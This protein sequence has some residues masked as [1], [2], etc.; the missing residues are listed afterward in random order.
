MGDSNVRERH[1]TSL[2]QLGILMSRFIVGLTGGIGSGKTAVSNAFAQLGIDII[3]A[4]VCARD[5]VV[6]GSDALQQ[7]AQH[8]GNGI[9]TEN[10]ELDRAALRQ[11]VFSNEAEKTWLNQLLH[12]LIRQ[13]MLDQ[14]SASQS[15]YCILAVPLLLENQMQSMV[16]RVLVV[17]VS[18]ELQIKRVI[19]RDQSEEKLI[20]SI[21]KSQLDRDSRLAFA[22]DVIDNQ[23]DL[24]ALQQQVDILHQN[25]LAMATQ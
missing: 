23:T 25:Y 1:S 13:R 5:V 22:D 7:I 12:P 19:D 18:P 6:K 9:L 4:D 21:M 17:D 8:F 15:T 2:Y 10:H 24:I 16:N 11:K 3:D 20:R 14:I